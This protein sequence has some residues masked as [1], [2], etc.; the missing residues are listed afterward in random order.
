STCPSEAI[1]LVRKADDAI[2]EPLADEMEW[3]KERG[4]RRGVDFSK[5]E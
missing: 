4:R 5:Y 3:Y 2:V 1:K